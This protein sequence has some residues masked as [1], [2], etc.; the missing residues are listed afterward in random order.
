MAE[1]NKKSVLKIKEKPVELIELFYDL[2]YV[3]AIS[4]LTELIELPES[5]WLP[6]T[7]VLRYLVLFFVI[8]QAWLYLTNY[9]NRYGTWTW[10]EYGLTVINMIAAM[11]LSNTISTAWE[12]NYVPFNTAMLVMLLT[13]TA[14]YFIQTKNKSVQPE[15]AVNS[16][17][18]LLI[19]CAIYAIGIVCILLGIQSIVIWLDV[20][21]VLVGAFLPFFLK[22]DFDIS[23]ISFPHLAE[24]FE[25]LT[26]IT[27]GESVV[28][29][30]GYFNIE[31]FTLLPILIFLVIITMYGSYVLQIH[32]L[33][34][35]HRVERALRLMF[36][37]YIIVIAVNLVTIGIH[38]L[39]A[40]DTIL[41]FVPILLIVAE[42]IF[43]IAMMADSAY[44]HKKYTSVKPELWKAAIANIIGILI[45]L[46]GH[47]NVYTIIVGM[48]VI[49]GSS[50]A[51][52]LQKYHRQ[53]K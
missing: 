40:S 2:I 31:H 45:T 23:I 38:M 28:G 16:I 13:V 33:V 43:Y 52:L 37:H 12:Y 34:D 18:I 26:I 36:S 50:F 17:K 25:L 53:K 5:G 1:N 15:A 27:F 29:M 32:Y 9:V 6:I 8:L 4:R 49:S 44:Y 11:Y 20:A 10:Y 39:H 48:L 51:Y 14:L 42:E 47:S 30:T 21:A 35:H 22:G 19:V 41:I 24:R 3:Y 7:D 46:I